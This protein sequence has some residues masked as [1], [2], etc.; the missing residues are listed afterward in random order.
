MKIYLSSY[1][2]GNNPDELSELVSGQKRIGV[3]RNALDF[4]DDESWIRLGWKLEFADLKR[5]GFHPEAIDLRDYF[6]NT[7]GLRALVQQLDALWVGGGNSFILN[8][9]F[10]QSGLTE[11]LYE[12]IPNEDFVYAAYSAGAC[13][14]APTLDGIDI[15]DDTEVI[16]PGYPDRVLWEGLG[17]IPFC[18]APHWQSDR[19]ESALIGKSIDYYIENKV[20]FIALRDGE[21]Y[22]AELREKPNGALQRALTS[23]PP[24]P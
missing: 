20:P 19:P 16:P 18:V 5:L 10:H 13:I 7:N 6:G 11:I 24:A 12:Q 3:I 1:R 17:L 2:I 23:G 14:L 22:I 21:T 8:S 9:A 15:V 4:S